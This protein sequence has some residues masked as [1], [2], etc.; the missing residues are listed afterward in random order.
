MR[1]A[2]PVLLLLLRIMVLMMRP[3]S[4]GGLARR[5]QRPQDMTWDESVCVS[6]PDYHTHIFQVGPPRLPRVRNSKFLCQAIILWPLHHIR[7]ERGNGIRRPNTNEK[8]ASPC[9]PSEREVRFA[10]GPHHRRHRRR[11]PVGTTVL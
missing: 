7:T 8:M 6:R 1:P 11:R 5:L 2:L 9:F 4:G 10:A 3:R